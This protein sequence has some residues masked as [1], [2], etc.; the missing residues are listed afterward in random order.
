MSIAVITGAS[1]GLGTCYVD[2]VTKVFPEIEELWLIARREDRLKEVA[3]KY[4]DKRCVVIPRPELQGR[5]S[6]HK[7][8]LA[9]YCRRRYDLGGVFDL[10]VRPQYKPDRLLRVK[11]LCVCVLSWLARGIEASENQC[12][13]H[14]SGSDAYRNESA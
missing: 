3:S 4:P 14:V 5:N 2:A 8:L 1:S 13:C 7:G 9:V 11:V 10:C 6:D 12:M